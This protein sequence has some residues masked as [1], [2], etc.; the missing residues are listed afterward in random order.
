MI[1]V[2]FSTRGT[3]RNGPTYAAAKNPAKE[4]Q[5]EDTKPAAKN[6]ANLENA[7]QSKAAKENAVAPAAEDRIITHKYIYVYICVN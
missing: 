2:N 1:G 4:E 3:G 6:P 5:K 7:P